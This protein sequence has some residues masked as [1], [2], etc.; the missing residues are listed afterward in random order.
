MGIID[1]IMSLFTA[2]DVNKLKKSEDWKSLDNEYSKIQESKITAEEKMLEA[3]KKYK[4]KEDENKR[5][6][7]KTGAMS[8]VK[9]K[10][11]LENREAIKVKSN[12]KGDTCSYCNHLILIDTPN[13]Y[14][15]VKCKKEYTDFKNQKRYGIY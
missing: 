6:G 13:R 10:K 2:V 12:Y 1:S 15:S 9:F 8:Y 5:L 4:E 3:L 11:M 7:I 14:C